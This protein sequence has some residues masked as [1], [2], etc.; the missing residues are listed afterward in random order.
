MMLIANKAI[1]SMLKCNNSGVL[2]M[3]DIEKAYDHDFIDW[4]GSC[5]GREYFR[6]PCP[7]FML[8]GDHCMP[9]VYFGG[10]FMVLY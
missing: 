3:L 7:F 9:P 8:C 10:A 6:F 5:W 4:L 2:C 1:D